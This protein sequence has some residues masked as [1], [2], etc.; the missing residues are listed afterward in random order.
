MGVRQ[1]NLGVNESNAA[2]LRLYESLGFRTFGREECF[3]RVEG[4]W[5]HELHMVCVIGEE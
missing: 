1:V 3:M 5:Q 2:A 4:H